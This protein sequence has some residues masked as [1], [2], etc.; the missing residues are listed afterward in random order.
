MIYID[1]GKLEVDVT[2]NKSL[3]LMQKAIRQYKIQ[4]VQIFYNQD[5]GDMSI[6]AESLQ[7][8]VVLCL[9]MSKMDVMGSIVQDEQASSEQK[10]D[11]KVQEGDYNPVN[12]SEGEEEYDIFNIPEEYDVLFGEDAW[13]EVGT[14]D[15]LSTIINKED[16]ILRFSTESSLVE[17]L[18]IS[19]CILEVDE[20]EITISGTISKF[21]LP[22]LSTEVEI[23]DLEAITEIKYYDEL[24][25]TATIIA[26]TLTKM[27]VPL[28]LQFIGISRGKIYSH[29]DRIIIDKSTWVTEDSYILNMQS[30]HWLKTL[31]VV[32]NERIYIKQE[33]GNF[34]TTNI[35]VM[36]I[37]FKSVS[38]NIEV[39]ESILTLL[40]ESN[41]TRLG[42]IKDLKMIKLLDKISANK[43]G[44]VNIV[45]DDKGTC[46]VKKGN[47]IAILETI[48]NFKSNVDFL[49][50]IK[51]LEIAFNAS[52]EK[53]P[54]LGLIK[55]NDTDN[56]ILY[57][58]QTVIIPCID[59]TKPV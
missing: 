39:I 19:R 14:L 33:Q 46:Y 18:S 40:N 24:D 16:T 36:G 54:G 50:N 27:E 31:T 55:E 37:S 22:K 58:L 23:E 1:K 15:T 47:N 56:L 12:I 28:G 4:E 17:I 45:S 48:H 57:G 43:D 49:V 11:Q 53:S 30:L 42:T 5:K 38:P 8:N 41:V 20:E 34:L 52:G 51:E 13:I 35:K 26:N 2:G 25:T 29:S 6:F 9:Q 59:N 10:S 32:S 44:I 21:R 3:A 7:Y